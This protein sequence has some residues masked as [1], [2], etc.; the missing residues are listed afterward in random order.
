MLRINV[1]NE[2]LAAS[3]FAISPLWELT[4]A[5]RRLAGY[6]Q[7]QG[8]PLR[9][10]T[11]AIPALEPWLARTHARYQD[12]V[13]EVDLAVIYALDG[14]GFGA[15]F[16][17]P[18]P[19]SVDTTI[20]DLLAQVRETPPDQAHREIAQVLRRYPVHSARIRRILDGNQVAEYAANVLAVAWEA[21]IEAQWPELR[22]L[23]ERDVVHRA[24]QLVARGWAAALADLSPHL[25]W[26]EGRLECALLS[27]ENG[28]DLGGRGLLFVPS[29]FVWPGMA[30]TLDPPWPPAAIYP[31][32][33]VAALW[34][35][36]ASTEKTRALDR[37]LGR[38]RAAV[39]FALED[40]ASTTQLAT[41]LGRSI[42]GLGDHLA[43]LHASGL[44][45]KA[46]SGRSVLY[47]RT[48][49]GDAL[50]AAAADNQKVDTQPDLLCLMGALV[51]A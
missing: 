9:S 1:S 51:P 23:L 15:S 38:S 8:S 12:V 5:L 10:R 17:S 41:V 30:F 49:V 26:R 42:G 46:R 25:E 48:A 16:L 37:L 24:G 40:P 22:A 32:R 4:C 3:R 11:G 33:G 34:E 29:V 44:V 7:T 18:I 31:A 35:T 43:V 14:P 27:A 47:R 6:Q 13:R 50:V 20:G 19:A 21:L 39:L 36:T 2:D 45:T 28:I